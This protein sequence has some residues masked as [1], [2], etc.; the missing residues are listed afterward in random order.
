MRRRSFLGLA[1]A[2]TVAGC[3]GDSVEESDDYLDVNGTSVPLVST[4]TAA[5]WYDSDDLLVLDAR[6]E[7]A[8]EEVR[9]AGA[10]SSPSP[11]GHDEDDPTDTVASDTRI[12]TYCVCPHTLAG[13][14]G[15]SLIDDGFTDVYA[16]D[17]GLEEWIEQGHPIEGTDVSEPTEQTVVPTS[18]YHE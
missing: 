5:E 18:D 12:L 16:L 7:D 1:L 10:K 15:A 4:D 13:Q 3:L 11:N 17:E 2:G 8:W 14:R 6:N 9:I